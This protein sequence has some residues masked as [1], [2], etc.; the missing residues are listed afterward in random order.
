MFALSDLKKDE[1]TKERKVA[2][3][4]PVHSW[5]GDGISTDQGTVKAEGT[6]TALTGCSDGEDEAYLYYM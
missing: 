3:I 5:L 2:M 6:R 4:S 1:K